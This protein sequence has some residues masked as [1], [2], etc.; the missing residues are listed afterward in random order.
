MI[1]TSV[2]KYEYALNQEALKPFIEQAYTTKNTNG[3]LG[4][5]VKGLNNLLNAT[6]NQGNDASNVIEDVKIDFWEDGFYIGIKHTGE[7]RYQKLTYYHKELWMFGIDG[8]KLE[9]E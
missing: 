5:A 7:K 2:G 9:L 3:T 1:K 4:K 6:D 8:S